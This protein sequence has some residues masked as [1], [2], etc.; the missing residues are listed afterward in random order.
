MSNESVPSTIDQDGGRLKPA[1]LIVRLKNLR[2]AHWRPAL[3]IVGLVGLSFGL[4]TLL[5]SQPTGAS[6]TVNVTSNS[7]GCALAAGN[8]T[9]NDRAAIQCDINYVSTDG[10]GIVELPSPD[11]FLSGG[12]VLESNVTLQIDTGGTLTQTQ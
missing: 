10:G 9:T 4:A 11:N 3:A 8:G 1:Q 12:L 6:V 7:T 5:S 2:G